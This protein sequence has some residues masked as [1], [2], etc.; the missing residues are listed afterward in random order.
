MVGSARF[1][2]MKWKDVF[3]DQ[4]ETTPLQLLKDTFN[5]NLPF[6]SLPL[7][8]EKIEWKVWLDDEAIWQRYATLSQIANL[9]GQQQEDVK[10]RVLEALK[11]ESTERNEK[12]QAAI[13]GFTY[14]A[15]TS[16]V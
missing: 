14:H 16:R 3:D 12:G 1:R 10:R 5:H 7:G 8:E 11:D 9:K 13:H 6:F 15:W 2:H 4:Q